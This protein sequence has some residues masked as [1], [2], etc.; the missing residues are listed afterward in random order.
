MY[1]GLGMIITTENSQN[2]KGSISLK[3]LF[4]QALPLER[5]V[6]AALTIND[7]QYKNKKRAELDSPFYFFNTLNVV[8]SVYIVTSDITGLPDEVTML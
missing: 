1:M 7:L 5:A 8:C 6:F 4:A 2:V 3:S